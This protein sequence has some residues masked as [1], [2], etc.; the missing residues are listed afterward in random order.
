MFKLC[1]HPYGCLERPGF[2][3]SHSYP[4]ILTELPTSGRISY[5]LALN[6]CLIS[7]NGYDDRTEVPLLRWPQVC[8]RKPIRKKFDGAIHANV[9][10]S[11]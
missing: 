9:Y 5:S 1:N 7:S 2:R 10:E 8:L 11:S 6:K 4:H 3:H